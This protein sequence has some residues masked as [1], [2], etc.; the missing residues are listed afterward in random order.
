MCQHVRCVWDALR[1]QALPREARPSTASPNGITGPDAP[2]QRAEHSY[3]RSHLSVQPY[4]VE[5][6]M[7]GGFGELR[8]ENINTY[9]VGERLFRKTVPVQM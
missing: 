5:G 1:D 7:E 3:G 4:P 8:Q 9:L 6:R 2:R